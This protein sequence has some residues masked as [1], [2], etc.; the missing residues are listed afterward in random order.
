LYANNVFLV[1]GKYALPIDSTVYQMKFYVLYNGQGSTRVGIYAHDAVNNSPSTLIVE[2]I[3]EVVL[4]GAGK[5]YT[6]SLPPTTLTAGTYW[7]AMMGRPINIGVDNGPGLP[8]AAGE[9]ST[10]WMG[11]TW[12]AMPSSFGGSSYTSYPGMVG[13][14]CHP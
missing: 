10:R 7:L 5:W 11:T 14:L 1:G 12:G 2:G 4:D 13:V 8:W 9:G 6:A 3:S